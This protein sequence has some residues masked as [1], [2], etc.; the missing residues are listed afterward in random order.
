[1]HLRD[2]IYIL[3]KNILYFFVTFIVTIFIYLIFYYTRPISFTAS[4][5]VISKQTISDITL[6]VVTGIPLIGETDTTPTQRIQKKYN[7][8]FIETV[9]K[10]TTL[11]AGNK[12]DLQKLSE[13]FPYL[14]EQIKR[15][16][17]YKNYTKEVQ[18][19]IGLSSPNEIVIRIE[20]AKEDI[21]LYV[22]AGFSLAF[23]QDGFEDANAGFRKQLDYYTEQHRKV[24][25]KL[26][27]LQK[28]IPFDYTERIEGLKQLENR[29]SALQEQI[30]NAKKAID[31]NIKNKSILQNIIKRHYQIDR[32]FDTFASSKTKEI[33]TTLITTKTEIQ[34]ELAFKNIE[35]PIIKKLTLKVNSLQDILFKSYQTDIINS[36]NQIEENIN[37]LQQEVMNLTTKLQLYTDRI[38]RVSK[39]LSDAK[40]Y[41]KEEEQLNK[42]IELIS[43]NINKY[44]TLLQ[45]NKSFVEIYNAPKIVTRNIFKFTKYFPI[46]LLLGL[47]FGFTAAYLAEYLEAN[48]ITEIDVKK[49]M[50]YDCLGMI[51]YDRSQDENNIILHKNEQ[52]LLPI[53]EIYKS[54]AS[55]IVK[56]IHD[57]K[58]NCFIISGI[59]RYE[60]KTTNAINLAYILS[61]AGYKCALI[62][63]DLRTRDL[64]SKLK[65]YF[66]LDTHKLNSVDNIYY[67]NITWKLDEVLKKIAQGEFEVLLRNLKSEYDFVITDAPPIMSVGETPFL[68]RSIKNLLLVIAS[69]EVPKA[70][71][72]WVKH[73][74]DTLDINV[75][76]VILNKAPL[77]VTPT[78]YYYYKY[79]YYK[80]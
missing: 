44:K 35:H 33:Y 40:G 59:G 13:K 6:Q 9:N 30:D 46:I 18:Y 24:L 42:Q 34:N 10:F 17:K 22:C 56:K 14:Q 78:Y 41:I 60:G 39:S 19:D 43:D 21:P 50:G 72:R 77:E 37:M 49:Y 29:Q 4:C 36:I 1:M 67:I 45:L 11:V 32:Y 2:Y 23:L 20:S 15:L 57:L 75:I 47:I 3:K 65:K 74:V 68:I 8:T 76:G 54:I 16:D 28:T 61:N 66:D 52:L 5:S 31:S 79:G 25:E 12:I 71:S 73:L 70:K 69:G 51:P 38:K 80:K 62:D 64:T 63:L 58:N 26:K 55:I 53:G 7:D 27:S 48:I